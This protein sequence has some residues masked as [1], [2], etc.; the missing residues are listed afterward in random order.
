MKR[1]TYEGESVIA[2]FGFNAY[3]TQEG[4][5]YDSRVEWGG[6]P[7]PGLSYVIGE[8]SRVIIRE[9]ND[10]GYVQLVIG[11]NGGGVQKS[12]TFIVEQIFPVVGEIQHGRSFSGSVEFIDNLCQEF[13][14][15]NDRVVIGI[16]HGLLVLMID[17]F[18]VV[19]GEYSAIGIVSFTVIE[20]GAIGVKDN[21]LLRFT[22]V[23]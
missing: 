18:N 3:D 9:P 15:G 2:I 17:F 6:M 12:I 13:V 19:G 10:K 16:Y 1:R 21:E 4:V 5:E 23:Q 14:G 7:I 22:Y 8:K 11:G 20:V